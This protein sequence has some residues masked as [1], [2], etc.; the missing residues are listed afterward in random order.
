M[1]KEA[2]LRLADNAVYYATS[3]DVEQEHVQ[4]L[5]KS[6]EALAKAVHELADA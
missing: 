4:L 5:V 2:A 1:S 6:I 3:F